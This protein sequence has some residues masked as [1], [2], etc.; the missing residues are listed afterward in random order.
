MIHNIIRD[1][2]TRLFI[3]LGGFFIT[4]AILAEIIG[5]KIFS[6]ED[7]LGFSKAS[8]TLLGQSGLSFDLTV[9]ILPWPVVF[10]MTDIINE[11]YGVKGVRFLSVLTAVLIAFVF[12]VFYIAI[13]TVPAEWWRV[14]Q[15][16]KGVPDM[17]AAFTQVVGQGMN[18]IFA[19]LTAFMIGQL[20]DARVFRGIKRL[21]GEKRIWMRATLSTLVSQLIDT[22]VVSYIYLYFSMGFSFPRV[23]AIAL[24]G[25]S[26][27]FT[28]AI[29]CTPLIYWIHDAIERYLG[30]EQAAG[31]KK[32]ALE[33][34]MNR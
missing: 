16:A 18:I 34:Q 29:L 24:V 13:H 22:V 31:M 11:Y 28:V 3:F 12:V 26:Y 32:A 27:K 20:T 9:G 15:E 23:T 25:Y 10:I 4:N 21:T 14:S 6:L 17:Q 19:S 1:K 7:T 8:F 33:M 2:P 30:H 5:V